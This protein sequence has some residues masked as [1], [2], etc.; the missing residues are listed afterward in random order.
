MN[1]AV[2]DAGAADKVGS[3]LN[4]NFDALQGAYDRIS[5]IA[6]GELKLD[7]YPNQIEMITS[8]QMLDAYSSIGMPLMYRPGHSASILPAMKRFIDTGCVASPMKS[9]SIP[10]P[11]LFTSWKKTPWQCKH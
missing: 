6:L 7:I 2:S 1:D 9:S 3:G 5:D 10:T 8:E 11:A 4:W